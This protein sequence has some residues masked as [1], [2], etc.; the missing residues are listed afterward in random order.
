MPL[1]RFIDLLYGGTYWLIVGALI[2]VALYTI[3]NALE[4]G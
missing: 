3:H 4:K 2:L 1:E